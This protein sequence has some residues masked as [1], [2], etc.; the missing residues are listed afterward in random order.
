MSISKVDCDLDSLT[1]ENIWKM[2][3]YLD[4]EGNIFIHFVDGGYDVGDLTPCADC[5]D[6]KDLSVLNLLKMALVTDSE[7]YLGLLVC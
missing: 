3:S 4:D 7:G 1:E 6:P 5:D 2:V